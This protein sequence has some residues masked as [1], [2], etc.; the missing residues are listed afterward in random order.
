MM[1]LLESTWLA[2]TI[3][4]N[5]HGALL[6]AVAASGVQARASHRRASVGA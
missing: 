1:F 3:W 5:Q 2:L 6:A 4:A